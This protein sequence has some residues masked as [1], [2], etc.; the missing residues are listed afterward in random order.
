IWAAA[1]DPQQFA[2]AALL[3]WALAVA[4]MDLMPVEG[5]ATASLSLSFPILL[6]VAMIYSAAVA[7]AVA[8][9]GSIDQRE[10]RREMPILKAVFVR[11]EVALS[12]MAA[13]VVFHAIAP[14][15]MMSPWYL[16]VPAVLAAVATDYVTNRVIVAYYL[17][18]ATRT[19]FRTALG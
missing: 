14:D 1:A 6:A 10:L 19:T 9:V 5:P 15:K 13:G 2:N 11:S 18:L 17:A 16:I 3:L 4:A 8:F 7:G 12:V